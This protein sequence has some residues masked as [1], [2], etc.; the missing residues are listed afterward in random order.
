[1]NDGELSK[2][3]YA[4]YVKDRLAGF[5][6]RAS[7][8]STRTWST[9][10]SSRSA[11]SATPGGPG[12]G[13]R[14]ATARSGSATRGAAETDAQNLTAALASVRPEEAFLTAASPMRQEYEAVVGDG[15]LLQVRRSA[16]RASADEDAPREIGHRGV[17]HNVHA[18][19]A[20]ASRAR[21]NGLLRAPAYVRFAVRL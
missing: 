18:E 6:A 15:L 13:R 9:S 12:V 16:A 19:R 1:M 17:A 7:R 11:S 10:R 3:S 2:P 14:R 4:T 5:G 8:S 20:F 21:A